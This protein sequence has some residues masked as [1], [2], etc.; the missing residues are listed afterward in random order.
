MAHFNYIKSGGVWGLFSLLT[1]GIMSTIDKTLYKCVN[2]DEGGTWAPHLPGS[3]IPTPIVIGGDGLQVLGP[4]LAT[5]AQITVP[6]G[7]TIIFQSNA[8]LLLQSG[9]L[10]FLSGTMTVEAGGVISTVDT[11]V[12]TIT[13]IGGLVVTSTGEAWVNPG[14]GLRLKTAPSFGG[15][16]MWIDG[17]AGL[18]FGGTGGNLSY[19]SAT[20]SLWTLGGGTIVGWGTGSSAVFGGNAL[21][22]FGTNTTLTLDGTVNAGATFLST[23]NGSWFWQGTGPSQT[24]G[25]E[26]GSY[27]TVF[28]DGGCTVADG[29]THTVTGG[30]TFSP[31]SVVNLNGQTNLGGLSTFT[32]TQPAKGSDPGANVLNALGQCKAWAVIDVDGSGSASLVDGYNISDTIAIPAK[33][34]VIQFVHPMASGPLSGIYAVTGHFLGPDP[35][36]TWSASGTVIA[37]NLNSAGFSVTVKNYTGAD[38]WDFSS[39]TGQGRVVFVV[40]GR[41]DP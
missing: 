22:S 20:N 34:M 18:T 25:V 24:A 39:S 37:A 21:A 1:S 27:C 33:Y 38:Q 40:F 26:F 3:S 29:A 9:S 8:G 5:N 13:N 36:G 11:G 4:F 23:L 15:G 12:I 32:G 2:G 16:A 30:Y 14:G 7:N 17:G 6:G 10:A 41:Q 31:I 19:L 35:N 28:F